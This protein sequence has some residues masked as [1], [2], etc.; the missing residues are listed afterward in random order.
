[1]F[2]FTLG[3]APVTWDYLRRNMSETTDYAYTV[4]SG[5]L[6]EAAAAIIIIFSVEDAGKCQEGYLQDNDSN[7]KFTLSWLN[8]F[9]F[10]F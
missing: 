7:Y 3:I 1:M 4:F 6:R 2:I 9:L 10:K 8:D 5:G